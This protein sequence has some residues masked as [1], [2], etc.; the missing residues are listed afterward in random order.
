M[1]K[2]EYI[3][4]KKLYLNDK[5][6]FTKIANILHINRKELSIRLKEEG[7]YSGK[8]YS[9]EQLMLA[10][11][12]LKQGKNLTYI[13]KELNVYRV[14]FGHALE[15][16]NIRKMNK[17][18][19]YNYNYNSPM[20]LNII[21]DY[22]NG[23]KRKDIL[24]KYNLGSDKLLYSLLNYYNIDISYDNK[25][26]NID[27]SIFETV[28]TE[29]KAYWL[30][31]LYADGYIYDCNNCY[32]L[33]L[34]LSKHDEEHLIK[35]KS[36]MKAGHPIYNKTVI[37]DDKEYESVRIDIGNRKIVRDLNKLGCMQAK[38]LIIEFPTLEQVPSYLQNS[39]IRGYFDGDGT[40]GA[41][42]RKDCITKQ[43]AFSLLGT[44]N[45]LDNIKDI[46]YNETGIGKE[47]NYDMN[48]KAYRLRY[49]G[50]RICKKIYEYLYSN[51]NIFLDRKKLVFCAVLGRDA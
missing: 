35:F 10:K 15:K 33:S 23:I 11:D 36:F 42:L 26:Y 28:D 37:L 21:E 34:S 30:G 20:A 24:I 2:K 50:N 4:A 12:M 41:Y 25:L 31:F 3:E 49:S 51:S 43:L 39:F 22:K 38:S 48:G 9:N 32:E 13:C 8:G 7:L 46:F 6:S 5:L 18:S 16:A 40:I 45:L 14:D 29:E 17:P 19:Y 47:K 1:T 27:E 44:K